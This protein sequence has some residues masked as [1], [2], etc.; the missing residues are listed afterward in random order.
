MNSSDANVK[1]LLPKSHLSRV[2][3]R[4]NINAQRIYE[5]EVGYPGFWVGACW[6]PDY[7]FLITPSFLRQLPWS[8]GWEWDSQLLEL[9]GGHE[10]VLR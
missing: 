8:P 5:M 6:W 4:D 3:I 10:S 7:S 2:I 9:I 1:K